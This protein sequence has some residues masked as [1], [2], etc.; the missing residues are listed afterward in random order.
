MQIMLN[1]VISSHLYLVNWKRG[2]KGQQ[3]IQ[4]QTDMQKHAKMQLFE[5]I[6]IKM[7]R[8]QQFLGILFHWSK[9]NILQVC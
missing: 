1:K 5:V 4:K 8:P 6:F 2:N 3:M 7:S 9:S